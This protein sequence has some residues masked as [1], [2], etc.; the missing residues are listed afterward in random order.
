M[1]HVAFII[2]AYWSRFGVSCVIIVITILGTSINHFIAY[3]I[4]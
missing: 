4:E 2:H 1:Y 3:V